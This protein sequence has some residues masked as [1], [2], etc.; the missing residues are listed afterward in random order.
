MVM[1]PTVEPAYAGPFAADRAET[2]H[3]E[4]R[5]GTVFAHRRLGTPSGNP[6]LV[7]LMRLR[8][9]IDHWD[10]AFLDPL[11]AEREVIVFDNRG[12]NA[13]TGT[14]ASSVSGM[15]DGAI[16]FLQALGLDQVDLLGWSLGG[17][18]ALGVALTEPSLVRR[19]VV[20]GST[21]GGVP[22][23][24]AMSEKVMSIVVKPDND[25]DDLLYL[26]FPD[27]P[28][29]RRTGTASLRRLDTRLDQSGAVVGPDAVAA[30]LTAI[31][32]FAGFWA[33]VD[34]VN[35]PV[36]VANG[37]D[38]VMIDAAASYALGRRLANAKTVLWS[39]SG[40]GFLF[41]RPVEF[42]REVNWFLSDVM[43]E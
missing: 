27:T 18:V 22:D 15:V 23:A 33:R 36:L 7:L 12:I 4:G 42:A 31:A 10:P 35:V 24:R 8:G 2:L 6:P 30:Q 16:D 17:I 38:D 43:P 28:D 13:S 5:D 3:V 40:H 9:T 19:L 37:I 21:P 39:D 11:A 14:P 29:G 41:Q 34:D 26:F 32:T 20:A 25:D 1:N